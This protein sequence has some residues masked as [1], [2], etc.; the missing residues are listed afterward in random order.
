MSETKAQRRDRKRRQRKKG[1]R[2]RGDQSVRLIWRQI[3]K[4]SKPIEIMTLKGDK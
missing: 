1:K 4:R 2:M 3:L